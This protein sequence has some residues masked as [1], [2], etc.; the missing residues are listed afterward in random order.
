MQHP[1]YLLRLPASA[2][3]AGFFAAL[4]LFTVTLAAAQETRSRKFTIK[5]LPLLAANGLVMLDYFAYDKTNQRLWVPAANTGC[6]DVM[7]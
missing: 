7:Q 3:N 6:V 5:P 2:W 1:S 4:I